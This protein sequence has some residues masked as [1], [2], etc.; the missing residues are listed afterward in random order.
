MPSR[1]HPKK[2][3]LFPIL[4]HARP[5][6]DRIINGGLEVSHGTMPS[7]H[8]FSGGDTIIEIAMVLKD[9]HAQFIQHQAS[10]IRK[11]DPVSLRGEKTFPDEILYGLMLAFRQPVS[12][13]FF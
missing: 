2:R 10:F 7:P 3:R 6:E 12:E 8:A 1:L 13:T 9:A 5:N 4:N 11:T